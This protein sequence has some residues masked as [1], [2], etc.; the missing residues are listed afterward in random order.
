VCGLAAVLKSKTPVI[1]NSTKLE[2]IDSSL[3]KII[4]RSLRAAPATESPLLA[5]PLACG[6]AVAERTRAMEFNK[7]VLSV[8]VADTGWRAE[9]QRLAPQYLAVINRYTGRSVNRIEFVVRPTVQMEEVRI[10]K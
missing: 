8:E 5:W 7:G 9:L 6:S 1:R 3:E 10:Q 2:A 4:S